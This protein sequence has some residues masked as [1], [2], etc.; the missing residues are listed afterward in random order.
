MAKGAA[1]ERVLGDLH[2]RVANVFN[3][4]L[5]EY[6]SRMDAE[7]AEVDADDPIGEPDRMPSPIMLGAITKFLKDNAVAFD[8]EEIEQLSA[9]QERLAARKAKRGK[10]ASLTTLEL[11]AT[12]G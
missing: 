8:T 6:E 1:N 5:V 11:V 3:K 9:T 2:A 10:L 12:S 4:V 7:P